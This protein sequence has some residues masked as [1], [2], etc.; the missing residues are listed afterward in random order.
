MALPLLPSLLLLSKQANALVKYGGVE[1]ERRVSNVTQKVRCHLIVM[2]PAKMC[3][4][5][6]DW[7][8]YNSANVS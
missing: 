8:P 3:L 5:H 6:H 4:D 7:I 1:E 2:K